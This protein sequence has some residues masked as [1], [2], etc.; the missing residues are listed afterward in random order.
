MCKKT[1][2]IIFYYYVYTFIF[3]M[4][5]FHFANI[6]NHIVI[7]PDFNVLV[8]IV[9][10]TFQCFYAVFYRS[11]FP[12][13]QCLWLNFAIHREIC[14]HVVAVYKM[15]RICNYILSIISCV[16]A[17]Q[18]FINFWCFPYFLFCSECNDRYC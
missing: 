15:F 12:R 18:V 4:I 7:F 3:I 17:K 5:S 2:K 1:N 8:L 16:H 11:D 6:I 14:M 10:S 13:C 9:F